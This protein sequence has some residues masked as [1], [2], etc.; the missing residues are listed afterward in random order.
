MMKAEKKFEDLPLLSHLTSEWYNAPQ[1]SASVREKILK[2]TMNKTTIPDVI[3]A[4]HNMHQV[5]HL[6]LLLHMAC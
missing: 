1:Y 4:G 3:N 5:S 6:R 2:L